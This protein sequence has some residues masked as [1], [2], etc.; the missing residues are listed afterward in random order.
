MK[1]TK[2]DKTLKYLEG[3]PVAPTA[4]VLCT[5]FGNSCPKTNIPS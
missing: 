4:D 5:T 3:D 2:Y 1:N